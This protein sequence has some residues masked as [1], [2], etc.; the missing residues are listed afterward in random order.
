MT[1]HD[2]MHVISLYQAFLV[3]QG[4]RARPLVLTS[5]SHEYLGEQDFELEEAIFQLLPARPGSGISFERFRNISTQVV[6]SEILDHTVRDLLWFTS[7]E[8]TALAL[9]DIK[10]KLRNLH[11]TRGFG[12][13]AIQDLVAPEHYARMPY[14]VPYFRSLYFRDPDYWVRLLRRFWA[15]RPAAVRP[16]LFSA[17]YW[18][19]ADEQRLNVDREEFAAWVE[20]AERPSRPRSSRIQQIV[21]TYL[22]YEVPYSLSPALKGQKISDILAQLRNAIYLPLMPTAIHAG[23]AVTEGNW[24]IGMK[25]ALAGGGIVVILAATVGLAEY[26]LNL[27]KR[28]MGRRR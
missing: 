18:A 16:V 24:V 11:E 25:I 1:D 28:W 10:H 17:L 4:P 3:A 15:V 13:S 2:L 8:E 26:L 5:L 22:E 27:P 19:V 14:P 20:V 21:N 12:I 7:Y 6:E 9:T 23:Q